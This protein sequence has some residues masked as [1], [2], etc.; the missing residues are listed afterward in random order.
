MKN[1]TLFRRFQCVFFFSL[2]PLFL[3]LI[4]SLLV[5]LILYIVE[6]CSET[7]LHTHTSATHIIC[8]IEK[9][10]CCAKSCERISLH[11]SCSSPSPCSLLSSYQSMCV[12]LY[13]YS[14]EFSFNFATA[15]TFSPITITSTHKSYALYPPASYLSALG[16]NSR[17]NM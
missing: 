15:K 4:D 8:E 3:R 12:Y 9:L 5:F 1:H 11:F 6:Y 10:F 16:A 17:F 7:P 14:C 13:T 2:L